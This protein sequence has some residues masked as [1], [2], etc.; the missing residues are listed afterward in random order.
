MYQPYPAAGQGPPPQRP[1]PPRP[2]LNAVKL[3]Y[4]GAGLS[5]ISFIV[6][7]TTIGSL[8]SAVRT[9]DPS[10]TT[11][12]VNAG[13]TFALVI[14]GF[15]ALAALNLTT[16]FLGPST[17]LTVLDHNSWGVFFAPFVFDSWG[18]IYGLLGVTILFAPVLLGAPKKERKLL[19]LYFLSTS[20]SIGLIS[21]IIWNSAFNGDGAFPYGSSSIDI[22]AQSIIFTL[23][24][25][26]LLRLVHQKSH[27][28]KY[29]RNSFAIIY[30]TLIV[31]TLWFVLLLEPIFVPSNEYNWRVHEIA[32]LIGILITVV[33]TA[34]RSSAL[35]QKEE[36][37]IIL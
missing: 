7:L 34:I 35:K 30:V 4:A 16:F 24:I 3:M 12:Q 32:F 1:E 29:A 22:A 27:L 11:S 13:V 31:T 19:S 17:I 5:A 36:S 37:K 10:L 18:T 25:M 21:T 8:K 28:E 20:V 15:F 23:S 26:A 33:Y 9:A 14:V 2:V 6:G